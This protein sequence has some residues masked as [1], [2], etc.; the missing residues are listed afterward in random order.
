MYSGIWLIYV[1]PLVSERGISFLPS[2]ELQGRQVLGARGVG[3]GNRFGVEAKLS[4]SKNLGLLLDL[5]SP[6]RLSDLPTTLEWRSGKEPPGPQVLWST[7][8]TYAEEPFV[9]QCLTGWHTLKIAQF[10]SFCDIPSFRFR[11]Q[12][13]FGLKRFI[14]AYISKIFFKDEC[15]KDNSLIRQMLFPFGFIMSKKPNCFACA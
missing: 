10:Q 14:V 11:G 2:D 5:N 9:Y 12:Y 1:I 6:F 15:R 13:R 4:P 3:E 7:V 8:I